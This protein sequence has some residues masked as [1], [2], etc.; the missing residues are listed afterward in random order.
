M[1]NS[2]LLQLAQPVNFDE[3]FKTKKF[4]ELLVILYALIGTLVVSSLLV[5]PLAIYLG[6]TQGLEGLQ[7]TLESPQNALLSFAILFSR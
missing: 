6:I 1:K 5:F 4:Y 3:G 2:A 7:E